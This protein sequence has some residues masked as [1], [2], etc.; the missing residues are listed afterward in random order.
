[1]AGLRFVPSRP[2]PVR[3]PATLQGWH[4]ITFLHWPCDA[5][6]LQARLPAGLTID[7]FDDTAWIG[8]T[9]FLLTGLR[10]PWLPPLPGLSDFPETNLRT[11]VR[12]P[13][14]PGIWFFSLD[15]ASLLMVGGAR[16]TYGLPYC[17]SAMA[18]QS[19]DK[20]V[21]YQSRRSSAEATITI[22]VGA[23]LSDPDDLVLFLTERYRLYTRW[24]GRLGTAAVE[25]KPW[26]LHQARLVT[27]C[28]TLRRAASLPSG[29]DPA[30]VHWS[31]G[32]D[33]RVGWPHWCPTTPVV[34]NLQPLTGS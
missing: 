24:A 10:P 29:D 22:E 1:M 16:L 34:P 20:L 21:Q 13:A 8:L 23:P 3:F 9:P 5:G 4:R 30:L 14:G 28:E 6:L 31:P 25:H 7:T 26:A 15:A 32:V 11:Y 19:N 18:I 27:G 33:V 17:W 12:G 2:E